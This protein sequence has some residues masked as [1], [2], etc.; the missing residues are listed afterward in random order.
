MKEIDPTTQKYPSESCK[1]LSLASKFDHFRFV[2][3]Y[4]RP[5]AKIGDIFVWV[6]YHG[7]LSIFH[8]TSLTF[9]SVSRD[10]VAKS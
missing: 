9:N 1:V 3:S 10:A 4:F 5:K 7:F 6:L 8:Q 2:W